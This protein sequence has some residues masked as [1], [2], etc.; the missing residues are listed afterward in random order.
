MT[1]F[2][3][4]WL[5]EDEVLLYRMETFHR[6]RVEAIA[7]GQSPLGKR[8][9]G[10]LVVHLIPRSCVQ[11]RNRFDAAKLK[12]HGGTV[13]A[14]GGRGGYARFNADGLLSFDGHEEVGAYSQL[15][16]DGRLEAAMPEVAYPMDRQQKNS[17]HCLRDSICEQAVFN[18]VGGYLRLCKSIGLSPPILMFSALSGV[19]AC[20]SALTGV[21]VT[22]PITVSTARR[23]ICPTS[24]SAPSTRNRSSSC[25]RGATRSGKPAAWSGHSTSISKATGGSGGARTQA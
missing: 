17:V 24:R 3:Q 13:P 15:Y 8:N 6:Q 10:L 7:S 4:T 23:C 19:K 16:R 21:S 20:A 9:D 1:T 14:L 2:A 25:V 12:E 5:S 22:C 11:G 18:T